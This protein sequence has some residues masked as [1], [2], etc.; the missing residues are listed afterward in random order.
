MNNQ[1]VVIVA[2]GSGSRMKSVLPKQFIELEGK[3]I[4]MRSIEVFYAYNSQITVVLV[5]PKDQIS[6]WKELCEKHNF[7][8]PHDI[9]EGGETRF[10]SVKNGLLKIKTEGYVA[11]HDGVRPLVNMD[12]IER[13][14]SGALEKGNAIPCI[15]VYESVRM[16]TARGNSIVDRSALRLIQTPQVFSLSLLK[17]AYQ[18]TETT[19]FTDDASVI[20]QLGFEINLVEGNRENIKITDPLDLVIAKHFFNF[21]V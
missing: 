18:Q 12:T 1:H 11:I 21:R 7:R 2:G 17:Q 10:Q 5:L 8:L 16:V 20:E 15:P 13:C 3:P 6:F 19:A 9:A 14:F 4:L